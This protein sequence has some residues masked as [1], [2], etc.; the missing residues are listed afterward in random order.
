MDEKT[1]NERNKK[2]KM[3]YLWPLLGLIIA[4]LWAWYLYFKPVDWVSVGMGFVTAGASLLWAFDYLDL[5]SGDGSS[6]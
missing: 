2:D 1:E 4:L 5:S 6:D 3:W